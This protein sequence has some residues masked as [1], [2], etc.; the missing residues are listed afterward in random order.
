MAARG[1]H[2]GIECMVAIAFGL[3]LLFFPG[4]LSWLSKASNAV[5]FSTDDLV[6]G[7]RKTF[8]VILIIISFYIF[9]VTLLTR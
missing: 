6:S 8:G 7:A 2:G 4:W 1:N 5:L 3:L 9:Y